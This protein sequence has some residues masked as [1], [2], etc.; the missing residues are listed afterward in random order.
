MGNIETTVNSVDSIT[1]D[2]SGISSEQRRLLAATIGW[3]EDNPTPLIVALLMDSMNARKEQVKDII[4]R[5]AI[6]AA[7]ATIASQVDTM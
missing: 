3:T 2:I 6:I 5:E 7:S 1:I 4:R